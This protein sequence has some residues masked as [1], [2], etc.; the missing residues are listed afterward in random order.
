IVIGPN[1]TGKTHAI[2][3]ALSYLGLKYKYVELS[4]SK[5]NKPLNKE[6]II[7][8]VLYSFQSLDNIKYD[9]NLIIETT[10]H[11][12]D[13]RFN[14]CT[15]VKFN[16]KV[17]K[18]KPILRHKKYKEKYEYQ[19][20]IFRFVGRIFYRKLKVKDL[21][22]DEQTIYYNCLKANKDNAISH[23]ANTVVDPKEN[24]ENKEL[25]ETVSRK[26]ILEES[27]SV[28]SNGMSI[29]ISFEEDDIF[30]SS[31]DNKAI[32]YSNDPISMSV[33]KL[34][35]LISTDFKQLEYNQE[36]NLSFD[37]NI[38]ER[39]IYEN[40]PYFIK[41]KDVSTVYD[42][43]SLTGLHK[44]FFLSL[45]ESILKSEPNEKNKF[46]SFKLKTRLNTAD[47]TSIKGMWQYQFNLN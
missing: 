16:Q 7:H 18:E 24:C 9:K 39:F 43:L 1:G 25:Y 45:I 4:E 47:T 41:L 14:S 12:I 34:K 5:I 20:D 26:F 35:K 10:L 22:N 15:V 17:F 3:S 44:R 28:M 29:S 11:G 21:E 38:I 23:I 42:C 32:V 19:L 8:T 31:D 40:F 30:D 6:C 33:I 46:F 2:I 13:G 36:C 37:I 27:E